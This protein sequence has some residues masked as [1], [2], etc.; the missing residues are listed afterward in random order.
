MKS[1]QCPHCTQTTETSALPG[2]HATC[3]RCREKF[4]VPL[5]GAKSKGAEFE[6][7]ECGELTRSGAAPGQK[8]T[9]RS[10]EAKIRVPLRDAPE[11]V[12]DEDEDEPT[13]NKPVVRRTCPECGERVPG[14]FDI[15]TECG[16]DIDALL[17]EQRYG[18]R[19]GPV[20][21]DNTFDFISTLGAP[22]GALA[23]TVAGVWF[24]VGWSN[25]VIFFYPPIL[26]VIGAIVFGGGM[27]RRTRSR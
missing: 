21:V 25:G 18:H 27:R 8:T 24:A 26:F 3:K 5:G 11:E 7:P 4:R 20:P 9:C 2:K 22:G 12:E 10:C 13:Q 16:A 19:D 17:K 23:M 6:C 1:L 14:K 15:C